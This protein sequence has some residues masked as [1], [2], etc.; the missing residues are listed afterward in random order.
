MNLQCLC[1]KIVTKIKQAGNELFTN[2][3]KIFN[4]EI[5]NSRMN[6]QLYSTKWW[7]NLEVNEDVSM[8]NTNVN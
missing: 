4:Q 8:I 6:N 3:S 2:K 1:F 7:H 5:I